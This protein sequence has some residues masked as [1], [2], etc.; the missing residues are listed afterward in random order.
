MITEGKVTKIFCMSDDFCKFFDAMTA[1]YT[2]KPTKK[3]NIIEILQC[4]HSTVKCN[5]RVKIS[6]RQDITSG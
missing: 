1:K 6:Q 2:L 4:T 5:T 3:V